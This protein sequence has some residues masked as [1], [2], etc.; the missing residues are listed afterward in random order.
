MPSGKSLW[1]EFWTYELELKAY[2]SKWNAQYMQN[3]KEGA[4]IKREWWNIWEKDDPPNCSYVIQ[5]QFV[6]LRTMVAI[7]L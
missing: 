6:R 7:I 3:P 5:A 2:V 4:I 1:P